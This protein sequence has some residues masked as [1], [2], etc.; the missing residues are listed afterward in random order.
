MNMMK[1][2]T[3][4]RPVMNEPWPIGLSLEEK[5][6]PEVERDDQ[7]KLEVVAAGICG[8]DVGIY[9]S[10]ETL[11]VEMSRLKQ[12]SVIVG[13]EFCAE[14]AD[15][16]D[17][18]RDTLARILYEKSKWMKQ[19]YDLQQFITNHSLAEMANSP[20][21]LPLIREKFY[22]TSE[23][24]VICGVCHQC[25]T[26]NGHAC[27]NTIIKG[28]QEDGAFAKYTVVP[29]SNITLI[30]K[31][32]I[33]PEVIA[34][35]DAFGNA[36]H[37]V[38]SVNLLGKRVA[39]L[40]CGVQGLMAIAIAKR[41]GASFIVATD[42]SNPAQGITREK[43]EKTKFAIARNV[44]ADVCFDMGI[45]DSKAK[46]VETVMRETDNTGVDAVFE[47][48]GS[49]FAYDDALNIIRMGGTF[50]LLGIPSRQVQ[51]DFANKVIFRGINI[52]AIIGRRMFETWET[53]ERILKS[54][55]ADLMMEN[56]FVSHVFP[57]EEFEK[58]FDA[59]EKGDAIK[60]V[61]KP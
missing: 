31:G 58:G 59:H 5:P 53:M 9:H 44:G 49:P 22:V 26:G 10:K 11:K 45:E 24:H 28:L 47:M 50:S 32:D 36:L 3:K 17:I 56:G 38:S 51:V 60:V 39:V 25:R 29:S 52:Q 14:V 42:V 15:A 41:A 12:D 13:H 6:I 37:T 1:A 46:L 57:L 23:M 18:A 34:F 7:V 4:P 43:L 55:M 35:M 54:G 40:G 20:D 21:L 2:L 8:T 30:R 27:Q 48:S 19:D 61:L 16:G 33:Q